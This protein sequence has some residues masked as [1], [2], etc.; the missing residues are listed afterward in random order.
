MIKYNVII[1]DLNGELLFEFKDV[2]PTIKAE[3]ITVTGNSFVKNQILELECVAKNVL[4][5]ELFPEPEKELKEEIT[6]NIVDTL[7]NNDFETVEEET[8]E[9]PSVDENTEGA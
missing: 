3:T 7:E 8:G 2:K 9:T 4:K 6:A 5:G 1:K